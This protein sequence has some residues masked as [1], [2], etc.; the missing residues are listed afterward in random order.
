MLETSFKNCEVRDFVFTADSTATSAHLDEI[1]E[2]KERR[3][4]RRGQVEEH[5]V[6]EVQGAMGGE[7]VKVGA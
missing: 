3:S 7:P 4:S 6:A 2:S 1:K 5:V